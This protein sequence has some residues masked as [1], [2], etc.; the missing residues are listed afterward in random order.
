MNGGI[1]GVHYAHLGLEFVFQCSIGGIIKTKIPE[2]DSL[3]CLSLRLKSQSYLL[4]RGGGKVK[5][6]EEE[7]KFS[8]LSAW[9][10]TGQRFL[11]QIQGTLHPET[12]LVESGRIRHTKASSLSSSHA[13]Q[14]RR[15]LRQKLKHLVPARVSSFR[16]SVSDTSSVLLSLPPWDFIYLYIY[17][18]TMRFADSS[19]TAS[20]VLF[21]SRNHWN[22]WHV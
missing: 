17:I 22:V 10:H 15:M 1:W 19:K 20:E 3:C 4:G 9:S 11:P 18:Y 8:V 16:V 6:Q 14:T 12:L 21:I 2:S 13:L 7:Y 5:L